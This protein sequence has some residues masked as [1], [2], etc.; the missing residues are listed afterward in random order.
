MLHPER[1]DVFS[2]VVLVAVGPLLQISFMIYIHHR[3]VLKLIT[4][5]KEMNGLEFGF[6]SCFFFIGHVLEWHAVGT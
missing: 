2:E 1:H 4:L 3:C 6:H 5:V